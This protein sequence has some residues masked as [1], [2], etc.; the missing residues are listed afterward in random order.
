MASERISWL[1]RSTSPLQ[2]VAAFAVAALLQKWLVL[3]LPKGV[4][5]DALHLSGTL[6]ANGGLALAL[7]CVSLFALQRT[8]IM[9]AHMPAQLI[10]RGPY[11]W[12]RNP[13]YVALLL[14][15]AGLALILDVPWAL[16]TMPLPLAVL[17]RTIV[18]FEEARLEARFGSAYRDYRAVVPR[19]L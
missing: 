8:T 2:F 16:L 6:L 5:L 9:P 15:Y 17:A 10:V 1:V 14:S 13:F 7:W 19:W 3:P 4:A 11:R 12:S 18:P